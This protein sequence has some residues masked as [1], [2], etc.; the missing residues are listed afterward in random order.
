MKGNFLEDGTYFIY[1]ENDNIDDNDEHYMTMSG[2]NKI[3][4]EF[5]IG[6]KIYYEDGL[7]IFSVKNIDVE[8]KR[9][10]VSCDLCCK[11]RCIITE[12]SA[13]SFDGDEKKFEII[14]DV[15]RSFLKKLND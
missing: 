12:G 13:V 15:D 1:D 5:K 10:N 6:E 8:K 9:L 3:I 7:Y 2:L 11:E 14:R 4:N